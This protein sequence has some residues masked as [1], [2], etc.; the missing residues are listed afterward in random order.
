[1]QVLERTELDA[2]HCCVWRLPAGTKLVHFVKDRE[3]P[4]LVS[5]CMREDICF[6]RVKSCSALVCPPT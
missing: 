1:M 4:H 6:F 5:T 3:V 2:G